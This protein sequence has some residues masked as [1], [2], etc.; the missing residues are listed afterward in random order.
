MAPF[1]I[2]FAS[3]TTAACGEALPVKHNESAGGLQRCAVPP[4]F[5]RPFT[6]KGERRQL[7]E[8]SGTALFLGN[9]MLGLVVGLLAAAL[10][11]P[12][13]PSTVCLNTCGVYL[14]DR[15]CDDCGPGAEFGAC[16]IGT[17]CAPTAGRG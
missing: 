17:A 16:P 4:A 12:P 10:P 6:M 13:P 5:G 15:D 1:L 7:K 14:S 2:A 9:K 11:S 8:R 3:Y